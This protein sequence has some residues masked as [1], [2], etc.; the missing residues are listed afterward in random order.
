MPSK[1]STN[2]GRFLDNWGL[3]RADPPEL[4]Q[5][6]QPVT[7]VGDDR[8][9]VS[10]RLGPSGVSGAN[11]AAPGAGI[12]AAFT[13]RVRADMWVKSTISSPVLNPFVFFWEASL[14]GATYTVPADDMPFI[15]P[16]SPGLFSPKS[17][18]GA[19]NVWSQ[20]TTAAAAPGID[21]TVYVGAGVPYTT[22][23]LH[24]PAGQ[25]FIIICSTANVG[26]AVSCVWYELPAHPAQ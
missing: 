21:P 3:R 8:A 10:H 19:Q 5:A 9:I 6:V 18:M 2:F 7:I 20:A 25:E 17:D 13:S 16:N 15:G 24:V 26:F 23:W 14:T 4:I 1:H 22:P 11:I 12:R